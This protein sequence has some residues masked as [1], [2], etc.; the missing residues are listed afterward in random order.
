MLKINF[1]LKIE[2]IKAVVFDMDGVLV[3]T[4]PCHDLAYQMV[5][6]HWEIEGPEYIEI[7][8]RSTREVI[9]EYAS[10]LSEKEQQECIE[11][12]QKTALELLTREEIVF[13]DTASVLLDLTN[14]KF[15]L[16]LATS[17]SLAGA[18]LVLNRLQA[19]N[20]FD[21][22]VTSEDVEH[23]KPAPDLFTKAINSMKVDANQTLIIEDSEAGIQAGLAAGSW[24]ASIREQ[25]GS[26]NHA[27]YVGHF[28]NLRDMY[29]RLFKSV[30]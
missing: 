20:L 11:F 26:V 6:L 27:Q 15:R 10:K 5:W 24:V 21:C 1:D 16:A 12:K 18:Q 25:P 19:E 29:Q 22:V 14:D 30:A 23:A 4:S 9:A 28:H 13:E 17:A 8:G 7:A 2:N 3:N